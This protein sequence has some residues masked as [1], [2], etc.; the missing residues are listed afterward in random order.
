MRSEEQH[1]WLE[2]AKDD[3]SAFETL[4]RE[5]NFA[6]AA[7]HLQQNAEKMLKA[8]CFKEGRPGFTHSSLDLLKKLQGMRVEVPEEAFQAARRLDPHYILSRYPNGV[9]GIPRDYY[10]P[11]MIEE[12]EKCA[13]TLMN[14][15]ESRL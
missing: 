5:G 13:K 6:M 1:W 2:S 4:R 15:V 3:W 12:L 11:A 9:G 14:F 7:F 8:L 10:D